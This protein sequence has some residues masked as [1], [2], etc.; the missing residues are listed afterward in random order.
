[1]RGEGVL[2]PQCPWFALPAS[3][4]PAQSEAI[5]EGP[6][7]QVSL[8]PGNQ[9]LERAQEGNEIGPLLRGE[10][11]VEAVVVEGDHVVERGG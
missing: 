11:H 1:M 3:G 10:P 6:Q 2:A 5:F 4:V 7:S 8:H 9:G